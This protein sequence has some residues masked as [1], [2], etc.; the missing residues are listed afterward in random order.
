MKDEKV[1]ISLSDVQHTVDNWIQTIGKGYFSELTNM[2]MLTEETGELARIIARR[3]GDQVAKNS[4]VISKEKMAD[5]MAD[6]LWVL[7]ALANQTGI[8]LTEAFQANLRKKQQRDAT[9]F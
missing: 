5:E 3:Y 9:R 7:S 2:V 6:I 1:T 8:D 4:D